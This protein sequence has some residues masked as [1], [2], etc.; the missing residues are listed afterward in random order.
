MPITA[1]LCSL[2]ATYACAA[3]GTCTDHIDDLATAGTATT[4]GA[5]PRIQE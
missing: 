3:S 2:L 5:P 4:L 1:L